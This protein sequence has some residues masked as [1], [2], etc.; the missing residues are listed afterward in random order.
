[1]SK[2]VLEELAEIIKKR[3]RSLPND[4]Y[5]AKLFKKGKVKIANKFGEEAVETISAFLYQEKKELLEE[6]SDLIFHLMILLEH[7][8]LNLS[9]VKKILKDRMKND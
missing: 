4:S 1:M 2:D 6:A 7:S 5:V 8:N 9:E 3:K